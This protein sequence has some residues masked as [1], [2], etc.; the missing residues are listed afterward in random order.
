MFIGVST[1]TYINIYVYTVFLRE[2]I[3][4]MYMHQENVLAKP[5]PRN[6]VLEEKKRYI[7]KEKKDNIT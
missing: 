1:H 3:T 7:F 5:V 2:K 4:Y 6:A